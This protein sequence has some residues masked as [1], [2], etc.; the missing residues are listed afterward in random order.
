[1][2]KIDFWW[3]REDVAHLK[4]EKKTKA[5]AETGIGLDKQGKKLGTKSE[6]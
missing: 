4:G 6:T 5:T 3:E 1:M 2:G